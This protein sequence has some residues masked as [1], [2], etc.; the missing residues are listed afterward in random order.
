MA[1]E[2][3]E[4]RPVKRTKTTEPIRADANEVVV[5]HMAAL[6]DDGQLADAPGTE[7][8]APGM[9][10]QVFGDEEM[11]W[12]IYRVH[13]SQIQPRCSDRGVGGCGS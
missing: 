3:Q 13:Q 11:V 5:F 9:C 2:H 7:P 4:Q 8:F 1:T 10:H 12:K 6:G